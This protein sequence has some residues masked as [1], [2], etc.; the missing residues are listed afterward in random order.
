MCESRTAEQIARDV[1]QRRANDKRVERYRK[2]KEKERQRNRFQKTEFTTQIW[3]PSLLPSSI[4]AAP[5]SRRIKQREREKARS[6]ENKIKVE[7]RKN[8]RDLDRI[9]REKKKNKKLSRR[10]EKHEKEDIIS[11][12]LSPSS[13][14][15]RVHPY[16]DDNWASDGKFYE[17]QILTEGTWTDTF[18]QA[19]QEFNQMVLDTLILSAD[20]VNGLGEHARMFRDA[21]YKF[22]LR[23]L[24][25]KDS[26]IA[27][28]TK[29]LM[30]IWHVISSSTLY[31]KVEPHSFLVGFL[32]LLYQAFISRSTAGM[33]ISIMCF[34]HSVVGPTH[35]AVSLLS[36]M[37]LSVLAHL[38][39]N[40]F[41][42]QKEPM[43]IVTEG[44]FLD[45]TDQF[46]N[47]LRKIVKTSILTDVRTLFC[48]LLSFKV[49][50]K[51]TS[52]VMVKIFG[53][54]Q[55]T[56]LIDFFFDSVEALI[57]LFRIME[58]YVLGTPLHECLFENDPV[59]AVIEKMNLLLLQE[60]NLSS[61]LYV[62]GKL[63]ERDFLTQ[64]KDA[65]NIGQSFLSKMAPS[66]ENRNKL[67]YAVT[68]MEISYAKVFGA[69]QAAMRPVP[70]AICLI[71][72]PGT[73]K[74]SLVTKLAH[75]NAVIRRGHFDPDEI[76]TRNPG[77]KYFEGLDP[78]GHKVMVFPELCNQSK[79]IAKMQQDLAFVELLSIIDCNKF[80]VDMAFEGKGVTYVN[81]ELVIVHTNNETLNAEEQ[82]M[83]RAAYFRRFDFF[84]EVKVKPEFRLDGSCCIDP[85]KISGDSEHFHLNKYLFTV[86]KRVP[87]DSYRFRVVPL[88]ESI[89]IFALNDLV[90]AAIEAHVVKTM[91][92]KATINNSDT[93]DRYDRKSE[94]Y[95]R[96]MMEMEESKTLVTEAEVYDTTGMQ[97]YNNSMLKCKGVSN[98][99]GGCL[100]GTFNSVKAW[101]FYGYGIWEHFIHFFCSLLILWMLECAINRLSSKTLK[102]ISYGL[103]MI[104]ILLLL[105]LLPLYLVSL[106][107]LIWWRV[108]VMFDLPDLAYFGAKFV[109]HKRKLLISNMW[110]VLIWKIKYAAGYESF[111]VFRDVRALISPETIV[112]ATATMAIVAAF[113]TSQRKSKRSVR[114]ES[115]F[116]EASRG[117]IIDPIKNLEQSLGCGKSYERIATRD[118]H[119][120]NTML[121]DRSISKFKGG[122]NELNNLAMGNVRRIIVSGTVNNRGHLF[123]LKGDFAL[124]NRH[125]F[126]GPIETHVVK[127]S[128]TCDDPCSDDAY[129]S[130]RVMPGCWRQVAGDLILVRLEGARFKNITPLISPENPPLSRDAKAAICDVQTRAFY[131]LEGLEI[132]DARDPDKTYILTPWWGYSW[133]DRNKGMCGWPLV[134]ETGNGCSIVGIHSAGG[135]EMGYSQAISL[136]TLGTLAF[137]VRTESLFEV[138]SMGDLTVPLE[139]PHFK[140]LTHYEDLTTVP[141]YGKVEG[142]ILAKNRSRLTRL[143]D[144]D[145]LLEVFDEYFAHPTVLYGIPMMN[146]VMRDGEYISPWNLSIKELKSTAPPVKWR[147]LFRA[148]KSY[149]HRIYKVLDKKNLKLSPLDMET[150]VNGVKNDAF[151]RRMNASTSAGFSWKGVKGDHMPID[152]T[153]EEWLTR[154]PSHELQERIAEIFACYEKEETGNP[155]F[156]AQLKDESRPL[157]KCQTGNTRLFYVSPVEQVIIARMLIAPLLTLMVEESEAFGTAVGIN[158]HKDADKLVKRLLHFSKMLVDGDI[159]KFDLKI[160]SY[161]K[162]AA[163]Q[164]LVGMAERYGYE[165]KAIRMLKCFLSDCL[166]PTIVALMDVFIKAGMQ[167]SGLYGTAEINSL[168]LMLC[169]LY[170]WYNTES[171]SHLEF[172]DHVSPETY[173]D[174]LLAAIKEDVIKHFN[175]THI[176]MGFKEFLGVTY[177]AGNKS[178]EVEPYSNI[179]NV[180]FLKRSFV[181]DALTLKWIAPLDIDS[182]YKMLEWHIPSSHVTL[183][184]QVLSTLCSFLYES[185]FHVRDWQRFRMLRQTLIGICSD[186]FEMTEAYLGLKLPTYEV[187]EESINS[188]YLVEPM[189]PMSISVWEE[190]AFSDKARIVS[191][192]E[193]RDTVLPGCSAPFSYTT[194]AG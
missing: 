82:V 98:A 116:C 26:Y 128:L 141:Y 97:F 115:K 151:L 100:K 166:F 159:K 31:G 22:F 57:K 160:P 39:S 46:F 168:V 169:L 147:P 41:D 182:M 107:A 137:D 95:K 30:K 129:I 59:E 187:I 15:L 190:D 43:K 33:T 6:Y 192:S 183:D 117:D 81:P 143:I 130:C 181:F 157:E 24:E 89:D 71:G 28:V 146:P 62:E 16:K 10:A 165:P 174:D 136:K 50:D 145:L 49:F 85:S 144:K 51:D 74:S 67:L 127:I 149:K 18:E 176:Q 139:R 75:I 148:M 135:A 77:A 161:I 103:Y 44:D 184:E 63:S 20:F 173:G 32:S 73:G 83:N 29:D 162:H 108:I 188:T 122:L 152:E 164:I 119:I 92:L 191:S 110:S 25:G 23:Q 86:T 12:I 40:Y 11:S 170:I 35:P 5:S 99:M 171:V 167:P 21:V 80:S 154:I 138:A 133:K 48:S 156:V 2:Q 94:A 185:Y 13:S 131:G 109:N 101:S 179:H 142:K 66:D 180:T 125:F 158:T 121:H 88:A 42:G 47:F 114:E 123:G 58:A 9:E 134:V 163:L 124:I 34:V 178:S 150:A 64:S 61:G 194:K 111:D 126:S 3:E 70:F 177:T 79:N 106:L 186:K 102:K 37:T 68:K 120:W 52:K 84:I 7:V 53:S 104:P 112:A 36:G 105:F 193:N 69:V 91:K 17:D 19:P 153:I 1:F 60:K 27:K 189:S 38:I 45:S 140:S 132:T 155:I 8:Q 54:I 76:F 56:N 113:Y 65:I 118:Q 78:I 4:P 55:P 93:F 96:V 87:I 14:P 72:E 172:F 90:S 175:N